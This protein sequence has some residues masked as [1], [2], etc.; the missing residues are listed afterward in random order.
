MQLDFF[1]GYRQEFKWQH[2]VLVD[3]YSAIF[4]IG[5]DT[6][7]Y[8]AVCRDNDG[9]SPTL[10][11]L[12]HATLVLYFDFRE[13]CVREHGLYPGA[14]NITKALAAHDC[15][16]AHNPLL[17]RRAMVVEGK[18][19]SPYTPEYFFHIGLCSHSEFLAWQEMAKGGS[20]RG[21]YDL[22]SSLFQR[23]AGGMTYTDFL[24]SHWM[25]SNGKK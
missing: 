7:K 10:A 12:M 6:K 3:T 17:W 25:S 16:D 22:L 11:E 18:P 24:R 20:T 13:D 5:G 4:S 9:H 2:P 19:F 21:I 14:Q 1:K 15:S 23:G 8:L